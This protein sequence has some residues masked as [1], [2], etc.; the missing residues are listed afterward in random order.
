MRI[1]HLNAGAGGMYCGS[2]LLGSMLSRALRQAGADVTLVPLY[3]AM[4]LDVPEEETAAVAFGGVNVFLQQHAALFRH[5]PP[6]LDRLFDHPALLR[7]AARFSGST[8]PQDL[9]R[10]CVSML[11]GEEGR[12][13]KEIRKLIGRLAAGPR[14]QVVHLANALLSGVA[15]PL[16]RELGAKVV[17]TLAGED[18]FLD[19]LPEPHRTAAWELLGRR[20]GELAGLT[21]LNAYYADETARR[22][23]IPRE[24]ITVIRPGLDLGGHA[25]LAPAAGLREPPQFTI[26]YLSRVA[27]EKG[28]HLLAEALMI[29]AGDARLPPLRVLA[30]GSLL[31][32]ERPYLEGIRRRLAEQG[33]AERFE[34]AGEPD[35]TAK[36]RLLERFDCLVLPSLFPESRGLIALEA[37]ANGAPT[38]LPST[39][40]LAELTAESGGGLL[41][42][43]G[44]AAELADALRRLILD[45]QLAHEC[46]RRGHAYVHQHC[47]AA[48]MAE[49][50][51]RWYRDLR[52]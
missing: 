2:C 15:Q 31:P 1:V 42:A 17:C 34:Y 36:I 27:P 22:L 26:G 49:E 51:L 47:S 52:P 41:F 28:L 19:Q 11:Q 40:A 48:R 45:P 33:L 5:T 46:S 14:P 9:G 29:L 23:K 21:A 44:D 38:V 16:A 35:R 50:T 24:R 20:A 30:A 4:R 13:R 3:T 39:G 43:P 12:Q 10:L 37:W 6:W 32:G 8:R 7:L 25:P 18:F